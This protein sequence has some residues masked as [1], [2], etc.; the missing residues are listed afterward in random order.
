MLKGFKIIQKRTCIFQV[1]SF[2]W[3]FVVFDSDDVS[4]NDDI[5]QVTLA[6]N[7]TS[8]THTHISRGSCR[9]DP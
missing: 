8:H 3:L 1:C 9:C 7:I 2:I 4:L 6:N 5:L